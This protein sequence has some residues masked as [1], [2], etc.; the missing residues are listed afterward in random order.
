MTGLSAGSTQM[1]LIEGFFIL[2]YLPAPVTLP[3]EPDPQTKISTFPPVSFH[4]SGP[5]I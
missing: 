5:G 2:K 3:P 4:I 1:T